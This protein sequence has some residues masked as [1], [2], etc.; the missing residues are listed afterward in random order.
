MLQEEKYK[1]LRPFDGEVY[2]VRLICAL[3]R[4]SDD[5]DPIATS[6]TISL[7]HRENVR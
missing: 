5:V 3:L 1:H 6:C 2:C 4:G 7:A